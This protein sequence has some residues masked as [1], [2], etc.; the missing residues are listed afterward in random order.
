[1]SFIVFLPLSVLNASD[2]HIFSR[3][4]ALLNISHLPGMTFTLVLVIGLVYFILATR[5]LWSR[6]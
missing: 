5:V 1:M 3:A 4:S 2:A 6:T